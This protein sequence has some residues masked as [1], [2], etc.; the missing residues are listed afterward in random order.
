MT[1]RESILR[2]R[3]FLSDGLLEV[4]TQI[5]VIIVITVS[6]SEDNDD[7]DNKG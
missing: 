7:D 2:T 6:D 1:W 5:G 4:Q 3:A